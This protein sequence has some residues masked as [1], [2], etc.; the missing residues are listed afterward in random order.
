ML[1]NFNMSKKNMLVLAFIIVVLTIA[2]CKPAE[3]ES[4]SNNVKPAEKSPILDNEIVK[5]DSK[6]K[7][8]MEVKEVVEV[9]EPVKEPEEVAGVIEKDVSELLLKTESRVKSLFYR[10]K[11][12]ETENDFYEFFI[13][14]NKIKYVVLK[15]PKSVDFDGIYDSIF[16][17]KKEKTAVSYCDDLLCKSNRGR[18]SDLNYDDAY[19]KTPFDWA[20][21]KSGK[22]IGEEVIFKRNTWKVETDNGFVWLD[23]FYGFPLRVE[24]NQGN[25]YRFESIDVNGVKDSDLIPSS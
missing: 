12:P 8:N 20:N 15:T 9:K 7:E 10:Y 21:I 5:E 13:K 25:E 22:K 2:A 16:I 11:G 24:D 14:D 19:I 18:K 3:K 1:L 6:L 17:D 23:S 4:E